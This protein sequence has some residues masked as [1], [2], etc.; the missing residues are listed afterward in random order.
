MEYGMRVHRHL[1]EHILTFTVNSTGECAGG[2]GEGK[3]VGMAWSCDL[4][5][6]PSFVKE[7]C[8]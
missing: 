3:G 2:E 7:R 4:S 8:S 6:V 5:F 1:Y